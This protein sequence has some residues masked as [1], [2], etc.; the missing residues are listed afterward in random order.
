M[1]I[2]TPLT[3]QLDA[4]RDDR[5]R[6]LIVGAGVAGL[7]L[8]QLLR[9]DGLH[10]VLVDRM[11]T[12]NHPGFALTLMP[13]VDQ[14]FTDLGV[15]EL[16]QAAGIPMKRY[17]FRSHRGKTL[18]TDSMSEL[19]SI[20]GD[21]T[22]IP[23]GDLIEVLTDG[24]CP[25][26]FGTTVDAVDAGVAHFVDHEGA[27]AGEAGFDLIVGADGIHSRM[28]DVL[29][30]GPLDAVSTGWSCWVAW[31]D[32]RGAADLGEELWGDGFFLGVYPVKGRV[33]VFLGG[34][35][36]DLT[37]GAAAFTASVRRRIDDVGPRL[38]AALTAVEQ[39]ADPYLWRL[40]DAGVSRWV[41]PKG[42][43][44]GDAAAGFLPT[45]GI[46]AGMAVESAWLLGRLL[47]GASP[48]GLAALLEA[49]ERTERPR[50]ESA[51]AN[52]RVLAKLMFRPGAFQAWLRETTMR[53]M[54][55]RAVLGPI[56]KLVAGRPDPDAVARTA[57][58]APAAS[59]GQPGRR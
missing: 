16:Y 14:A 55:V 23:R 24:G 40:D 10:P 28:R 31:A 52:S 7:T 54:S 33:G 1:L 11:P 39:N 44:L 47:A 12:M 6:V 38:E 29:D 50:V 20:Y 8:A 9:R 46:G 56:V 34:P 57:S 45:A 36:A 13:T 15:H 51:Q 25:V 22:G 18:R 5:L 35:N 3:T 30:A 21:Y 37:A 27:A 41:L 42:I 26:T 43:L 4:Q 19:L 49:W 53:L 48:D 32:E 58:P 17:S 59:A 2:D